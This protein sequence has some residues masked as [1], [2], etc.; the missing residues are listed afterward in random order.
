[1][2]KLFV[3]YNNINN[4]IKI[5]D[6]KYLKMNNKLKGKERFYYLT[7]KEGYQVLEEYINRKTKKFLRI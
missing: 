7:N 3:I 2:R 5:I 1:M 4:L 6:R